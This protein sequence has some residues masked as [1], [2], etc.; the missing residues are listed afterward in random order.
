MLGATRMPLSAGMGSAVEGPEDDGLPVSNVWML[1]TWADLEE[2]SS[3]LEWA[4][5]A[6]LAGW[7][8]RS[9]VFQM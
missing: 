2:V 5:E 9:S 4:A 8:R 7:W 1:W 6:I 3:L